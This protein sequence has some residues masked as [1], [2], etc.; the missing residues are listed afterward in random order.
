MRIFVAGATG[1]LGRR[2]VPLLVEGGHQVT[3]MTRTAGKAAGLRAA[4]ADP[5]V[6]DALDRDAVLRAVEAAR[7]EV[8]MHQLTAL[9]GTTSMRR[10]DR[11]FALTDR[12]RTEGTDHLLDA[13]RA[14]GAR[15]FV[16]QSFAGWPFARVGGPVKTEDDPLDPDPPAQ[17]RR[18]LDAIRHL[19]AAVSGTEGLEGVV[20]RYGGFY[21]P[22]T[23]A[24]AGGSILEDLRRRRFPILG[25]GGGVWSF[26]HI[27]DAATA[28]AAAIERGAPGVYQVVD[29][30]PAPVSEWLPA[31]AAA[32][33]APR[34]L[35]VPAWVARLVAGEHAVVLMTEVR[36]A[37]NAKARRELGWRP[38]WPSWRQGFRTGLGEAAARPY[39]ARK[40]S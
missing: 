20:L 15:R 12:L 22:G 8:V 2:L 39:R 27:D 21:G 13:A 4:G 19:E 26:I 1:A 16:A 28:T 14:A 9:A 33:G 23:S 11:M 5:V 3:G 25:D 38:G 36:G 29:D 31:L 17:V 7:P 37:S 40:G 32:I 24:G 18:T 10:F 35:R 30:D 34:P 6:A